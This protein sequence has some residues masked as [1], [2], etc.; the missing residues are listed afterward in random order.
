M[1]AFVA[2]DFETADQGRDSACSL[3]LVTVENGRVTDT[4]QRLIRPPRPRMLYTHIHGITWDMV[5]DQPDFG[6]LWPDIRDR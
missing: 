4:W 2:L 3:A 6:H 5:A 1:T